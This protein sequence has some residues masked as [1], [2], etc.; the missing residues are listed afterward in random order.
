M[1]KFGSEVP[2]RMRQGGRLARCVAGF[3]RA[4]LTMKKLVW[5]GSSLVVSL[6]SLIWVLSVSVIP[7]VSRQFSRFL[8]VLHAH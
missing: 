8:P 2:W 3:D 4:A 6:W 1:G 5:C 7:L